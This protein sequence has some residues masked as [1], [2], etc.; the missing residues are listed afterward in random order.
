MTAIIILITLKSTTHA[1][2]MGIAE[3]YKFDEDQTDEEKE[4]QKGRQNH[5]ALYALWIIIGCVVLILIFFIVAGSIRAFRNPRRYGRRARRR[6]V[7]DTP[8]SQTVTIQDNFQIRAAGIARA[9]LETF[10]LVK[11]NDENLHKVD[12][13]K[14]TQDIELG[15]TSQKPDSENTNNC[16]ICYE[17]FQNGEQLRILPCSLKHCFHSSCIDQWLLEIQGVCPLCRKDFRDTKLQAE[18]SNSSNSLTF[19]SRSTAHL[20]GRRHVSLQSFRNALRLS[21]CTH[22]QSAHELHP[23]S[24]HFEEADITDSR[25]NRVDN[26]ADSGNSNSH[27]SN[28]NNQGNNTHNID[29]DHPA[30]SASPYLF[31][32]LFCRIMNN[33]SADRV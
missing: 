29:I 16:A 23:I 17:D 2:S 9:I 11:F 24:E 22:S 33:H 10:P 14:S 32:S 12:N 28:S 31:T 6:R 7:T 5:I 21:R 20:P 3:L 4:A 13:D 18:A 30:T 25:D 15:D 8:N 27:I 26:Q 19:L 1:F